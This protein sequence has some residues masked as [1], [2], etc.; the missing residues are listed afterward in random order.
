MAEWLLALVLGAVQGLLEWLPVSSEGAVTLALT[1]VDAGSEAATQLALSL[2][3][4]T[5]VAATVYYREELADVVSDVPAWRPRS[6]F[7]R[8]TADLSFFAVATLVSGGVGFGGYLALA[9]VASA[10]AGGT[11]VALIGALLVATGLFMRLAESRAM[12]VRASPDLLDALV[13]GVLQGLAVLPG[14]SRSGTTVSALLLRGHEGPASLRLSFV[15]SIPAAAGAGLLVFLDEGVPAVEPA[16]ALVA[17]VV[18]AVVGYLTVDALVRVV[19][20]VAFWRVCVGFGGLAV[21][22]GGLL[23]V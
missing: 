21:V 15:L 18:S 23:V 5:A 11:F 10:V 14:V 9:E 20:R 4:G 1:A 3:A 19:E 16:T 8:S 17:L 13:V 7:S 2:H 12:E 22:G 6:A